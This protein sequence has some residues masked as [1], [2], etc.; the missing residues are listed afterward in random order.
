MGILGGMAFQPYFSSDNT[1]LSELN[2]I[3]AQEPTEPTLQRFFLLRF[4]MLLVGCLLVSCYPLAIEQ[5]AIENG[6]LVR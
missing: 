6:H 3:R 5:F 2:H 4:L 1:L